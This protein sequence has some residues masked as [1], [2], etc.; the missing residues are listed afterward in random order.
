[1]NS[2]SNNSISNI[3]TTPETKNSEFQLANSWFDST[4]RNVWDQLISQINPSKIDAFTNIYA[5]KI[6]IISA[7]LY[8]LYVEKVSD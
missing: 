6:N 2:E 7:P 3:I 1:M 8:Q 5:R 4:V